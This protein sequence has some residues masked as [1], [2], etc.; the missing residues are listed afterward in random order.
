MN[1]FFVFIVSK[2]V[3]KKLD[4]MHVSTMFLSPDL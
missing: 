4:W 3:D 1:Y 2:I